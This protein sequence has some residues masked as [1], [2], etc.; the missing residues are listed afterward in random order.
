MAIVSL[1][2]DGRDLPPEE[3]QLHVLPCYVPYK[4][5]G[6]I[7]DWTTKGEVVGD[8]DNSRPV[9]GIAF[10]T[11]DRSLLIEVAKDEYHCTTGVKDQNR[12]RPA[13]VSL[14]YFRHRG[15]WRKNHGRYHYDRFGYH[16]KN[17]CKCK[18]LTANRKFSK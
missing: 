1:N 6:P 14:V 8:S 5:S 12:L 7:D 13:R 18:V 11:P 15:L 2:K 16:K 10:N 3:S 9:G 4:P 17:N